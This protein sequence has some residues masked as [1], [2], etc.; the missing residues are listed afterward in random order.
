M[1]SISR[2]AVDDMSDMPRVAPMSS[3]KNSGPSPS[4][5]IEAVVLN[6]MRMTP[7]VKMKSIS[8][9][10]TAEWALISMGMKRSPRPASLDQIKEKSAMN[11]PAQKKK[12][13]GA[14]EA[15]G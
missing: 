6:H 2:L 8:F 10:R 12:A 3:V 5:I 13:A 7:M 11:N 9:H 1:K 14:G 15:T 4:C